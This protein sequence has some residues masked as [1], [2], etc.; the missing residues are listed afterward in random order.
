MMIVVVNDDNDN[1]SNDDNSNDNDG[2]IDS[3]LR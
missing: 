1:D 2:L 3:I